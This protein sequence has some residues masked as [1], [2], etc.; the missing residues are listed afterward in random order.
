MEKDDNIQTVSENVF[1][2]V[3]FAEERPA[4]VQKKKSLFRRIINNITIEPALFIIM[5]AS[6]LDNIASEQL[7]LWKS[8]I[9]DFNF[10]EEICDNLTNE[11]YEA[12]KG[13]VADELTNFNFIKTLVTSIFPT[14][15]AF[16]LGAWAD[17]FGRK[18]IFYLFLSSYALEQ[19]VVWYVPTFLIHQKN[20]YCCP[21]SQKIWLVDLQLGPYLS[22][23]SYQISQ[24]LKIEL[25]DLV[26]LD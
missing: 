23:L 3:E 12:E 24:H 19:G 8:C 11:T 2:D 7:V 5:F 26:C 1:E 18:P 20:G 16:Y 21:T 6:G 22:M 4:A 13:M 15:M 10:T 14:V 25:S 9:N 17:M